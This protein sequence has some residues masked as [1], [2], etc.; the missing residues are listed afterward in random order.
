LKINNDRRIGLIA[1]SIIFTT[2]SFIQA[3]TEITADVKYSTLFDSI[4]VT[5]LHVD[6]IETWMEKPIQLKTNSSFSVVDIELDSASEVL[7]MAE[8]YF[9]LRLGGA[10]IQA[11]DTK[12]YSILHDYY[13][14]DESFF[15]NA[16][17]RN[18]SFVYFK[19]VL[20]VM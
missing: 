8:Q 2:S 14:T 18:K 20:E 17:L 9:P 7:Y 10:K 4:S 6:D 12:D 15:Q 11:I 19:N 1:I 5:R 13:N 3:E 16:L